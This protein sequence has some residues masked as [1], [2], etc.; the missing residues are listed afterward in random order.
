MK[1]GILLVLT[2]FLFSC[3][4]KP[5]YVVKEDFNQVKEKVEKN[6]FAVKQSL[7]SIVEIKRAFKEVNEQLRK[8]NKINKELFT[9]IEKLKANIAKIKN[10]NSSKTKAKK[11][12]VLS[13][14]LNFRKNPYITPDNIIKRLKRGDIVTVIGKVGDWYKVKVNGMTGYIHKNFVK[15]I[16]N[17]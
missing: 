7:A 16:D 10:V 11:A 5:K 4:E 17:D 13:T 6:T 1:K 14:K 12:V 2:V 8:Q 15:V 9:E 3:A